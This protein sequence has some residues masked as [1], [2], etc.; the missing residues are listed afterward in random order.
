MNCEDEQRYLDPYLD[1]ELEVEKRLEVE[2]HLNECPNCRKLLEQQRKF[3]DFFNAK[4]PFYPAPDELR[5]RVRAALKAQVQKRKIISLVP[6]PWL[7]AAALL[8]LSLCLAWPLLF[9]DRDKHLV[10]DA[11]LN[12][13]RAVLLGR[14]YE[15]NSPDPG[16]VKDWLTAKLGFSPPVV[17]PSDP[18]FQ[19][20]GGRVDVI[21]DRKVAALVYKRSQD[22]IS[23]FVWP[24][25]DKPLRD[26]DWSISGYQA[27]TWNAANSNF[28]AIS[29]LS[30][31]D[32]DEFIDQIRD[33]LK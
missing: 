19:M 30:D 23:L 13:S 17:R 25:A 15:V 27:C 18:Q 22:V 6:Q 10:S 26:K 28:V 29:A 5:A 3:R 4:A 31:H 20:Q 8:V 11:A 2:Q 9:P 14:L 21:G 16:V 24:A 33:Q 12:H 7:Y 32:L 1:G